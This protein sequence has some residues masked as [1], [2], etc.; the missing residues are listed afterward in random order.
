MENKKKEERTHDS[1]VCVF[2]ELTEMVGFKE[3]S[4]ILPPLQFLGFGEQVYY[5]LSYK[6]SYFNSIQPSPSPFFLSRGR[7]GFIS[8]SLRDWFS[9]REIFWRGLQKD[10]IRIFDDCLFFAGDILKY[11]YD[12]SGSGSAKCITVSPCTHWCRRKDGLELITTILSDSEP[13]TYLP[14]IGN[15]FIWLFIIYF[16]LSRKKKEMMLLNTSFL[17]FIFPCYFFYRWYTLKKLLDGKM[18][19]RSELLFLNLKGNERPESRGTSNSNNHGWRNFI[20]R[21]LKMILKS[22]PHRSDIFFQQNHTTISNLPRSK[23]PFATFTSLAWSFF[24]SLF[25]ETC[26]LVDV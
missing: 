26:W 3:E 1:I 13:L 4:N 15:L 10:I 17:V 20:L 23:N 25:T 2:L 12:D 22:N 11:L 7:F 19:Q 16:S 18:I 24:F 8:M 9:T 5:L 14:R 21:F 6:L